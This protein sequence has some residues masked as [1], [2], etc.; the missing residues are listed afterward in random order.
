MLE[1]LI[2]HSLVI[3]VLLTWHMLL[4]VLCVGNDGL[5]PS[6]QVLLLIFFKVSCDQRLKYVC[7]S[8]GSQ[9]EPAARARACFSF[10]L[11]KCLNNIDT[12][13]VHDL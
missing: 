8:A 10:I 5:F 1:S 11:S 3:R 7:A 6:Y 12:Y 9:S 13:S 4:H 2:E